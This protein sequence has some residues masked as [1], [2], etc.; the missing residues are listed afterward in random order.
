MYYLQY[1]HPPNL[2]SESDT[3]EFHPNLTPIPSRALPASEIQPPRKS[4]TPPPPL[5]SDQHVRKG[6]GKKEIATGGLLLLAGYSYGSLIT[7]CL[8]STSDILVVFSRPD[9][10]SAASE[11]RLRAE[12]LARQQSD[13]LAA[14]ALPPD[15]VNHGRR[16][17][18]IDDARLSPSARFG[19]EE[20]S[21]G[22]RR[23]SHE[24][25]RSLD[26]KKL[27]RSLDKIKYVGLHPPPHSFSRHSNRGSQSSENPSIHENS[28]N[29]RTRSTASDMTS[30]TGG[31]LSKQKSDVSQVEPIELL[32]LRS[33]YLLIS[34]LQGLIKELATMSILHRFNNLLSQKPKSDASTSK[35]AHQM[36]KLAQ[37]DTL[38]IFGTADI[39]TSEKKLYAWARKLENQESGPT[40][41]KLGRSKFRWREVE[42]ADHF[43]H[44]HEDVS[45]L[46]DEVKTFIRS[47]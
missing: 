38:A 45:I 28:E 34:P 19:G 20:T 35:G 18:Q 40:A 25:R 5:M 43:W 4:Y 33:A 16:S 11:I 24:G 23:S 14:M 41:K 7:T 8:P 27:R 32:P 42:G 37:N 9:V 12:H 47:L 30:E 39:F 36:D 13:S 46:R 1:L 10:G 3:E 44:N 22:D 26:T 17:L 15:P 2:P 21:P 31:G 29:R 6:R